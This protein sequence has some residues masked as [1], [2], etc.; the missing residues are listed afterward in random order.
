MSYLEDLEHQ[1]LENLKREVAE[2]NKRQAEERA[3]R[4]RPLYVHIQEWF[5]SLPPDSRSATYT[6]EQL[7][8]LFNTAPGLIGAALHRLGWERKRRWN[9]GGAFTRYWIPPRSFTAP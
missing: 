9:S 4:S 2:I 8:Q 6:M 7:V 3:L 1:Y 5:D